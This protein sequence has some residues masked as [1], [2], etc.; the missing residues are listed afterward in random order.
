MKNN[1]FIRFLSEK[2]IKDNKNGIRILAELKRGINKKPYECH[3][4][5][6]NIINFI[7]ENCTKTEENTYFII[8]SL[9]ATY[10]NHSYDVKSIGD[11][12]QKFVN[13]NGKYDQKQKESK[14]KYFFKLLNSDIDDLPFILKRIIKLISS[15]N[16]PINYEILFDTI[17][18]WNSE[19]NMIKKTLAKDFWNYKEEEREEE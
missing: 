1:A 17:L 12:F 10:P 16:V 19:N 8:A 13:Q 7:P 3:S 18:Y 2:A 11:S 5:S 9:Y 15:S 14:E 6:K 4:V